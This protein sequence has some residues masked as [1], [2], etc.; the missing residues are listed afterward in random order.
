ME[1][2]T[3][4]KVRR[5]RLQVYLRPEIIRQLKRHRGETDIPFGRTIEDALAKHFEKTNP[6]EPAM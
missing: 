5:D 2:K 4:E 1:T 3:P 6:T